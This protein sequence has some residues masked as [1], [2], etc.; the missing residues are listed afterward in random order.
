MTQPTIFI[1]HDIYENYRAM[2]YFTSI[3]NAVKHE[4][5]L[6]PDTIINDREEKDE[7]NGRYVTIHLLAPNSDTIKIELFFTELH[8]IA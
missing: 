8:I 4:L 6:Y 1:S 3:D 7:D 5:S 2:G